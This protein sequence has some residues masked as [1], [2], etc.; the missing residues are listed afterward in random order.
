MMGE[1]VSGEP[2]CE[3]CRWRSELV[4]CLG[5]RIEIRHYDPARLAAAL[6]LPEPELMAALG[7]RDTREIRERCERSLTARRALTAGRASV[8]SLCRHDPRWPL[9]RSAAR[10][11]G[12]PAVLHVFGNAS[13]LEAVSACR[14]VAIVG[15]SRATDYGREVA[16]AFGREL[17]QSGLAVL[18]GLGE[19]IAAAAHAGALEAGGPTLTAMPGG[20][21]VCSPAGARALYSEIVASGCAISE[22]PCGMRPRRWCYPA[23]SRLIAG[24]ATVVVVVEAEDRP[25]DLSLARFA[26]DLGRGVAAVPGRITSPAS[27]GTHELLAEGARL[28]RCTQD[29][30]DMLAAQAPAGPPVGGRAPAPKQ[31]PPGAAPPAVASSAPRALDDELG[32]LLA[33]VRGGADTPERLRTKGRSPQQTLAGLARLELAGAL[34]RGDGGRYVPTVAASG[35]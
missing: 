26:R 12:A 27:R 11:W 32:A 16:R 20:V 1:R 15:T 21:D 10:S 2:P 30:L 6:A 18:S 13:A 5:A 24:L 34:R 9:P 35:M 28:V 4:T 33:D 8:L 19:G 7:V 29:I 3:A 31:A 17:A 25:S 23:R 14:A 22:L